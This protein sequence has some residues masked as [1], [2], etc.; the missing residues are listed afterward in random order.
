M[1]KIP[2][3][4]QILDWIYEKY[5]PEFT[6]FTRETPTRNAKVYVPIDIEALGKHFKIDADIIFGRLYYYL[7][8]KHAYQQADES[9][10]HL[11]AKN[12]GSDRHVINFPVLS[13]LLANMRQERKR[14]RLTIGFSISALVISILSLGIAAVKA[15]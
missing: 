15:F 10:V 14:Y 8:N 7:D 6:N 3:D 4:L 9:W 2:T 13:S 1:K 12:A 11:F 5:Y